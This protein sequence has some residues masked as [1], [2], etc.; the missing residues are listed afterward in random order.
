[1]KPGNYFLVLNL[2]CAV[3]LAAAWLLC[4]TPAML[5]LSTFQTSKL[6]EQ[7]PWDVWVLQARQ[8]ITSD[9]VLDQPEELFFAAL[10]C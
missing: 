4:P 3:A 2:V 8:P 1:M 9:T 10:L 6:V 7:Q 5:G